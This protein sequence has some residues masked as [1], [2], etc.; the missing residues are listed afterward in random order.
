MEVKLVNFLRFYQKGRDSKNITP[1]L[2]I[3]FVPKNSSFKIIKVSV[4]LK[5]HIITYRRMVA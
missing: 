2:R 3:I 4:P 5:Q 1:C